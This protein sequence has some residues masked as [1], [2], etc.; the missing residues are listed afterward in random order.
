MKQAVKNSGFSILS[1]MMYIA[2]ITTSIGLTIPLVCQ[3][4]K[5]ILACIHGMH[6][7]FVHEYAFEIMKSDIICAPS[8]ITLWKFRDNYISFKNSEIKIAWAY[9]NTH[10]YRI[11]KTSNSEK[12]NRIEKKIFLQNIQ[13]IVFDIIQDTQQVQKIVCTVT[14]KNNSRSYQFLLRS[15]LCV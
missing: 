9:N 4:Y 11:E 7:D 15:G 12:Q 8:D 10:L 1:F 6:H 14:E 2:I 3:L 5:N 13:N